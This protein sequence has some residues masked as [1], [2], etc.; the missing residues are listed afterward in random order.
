M[1]SRRF[2]EKHLPAYA[3]SASDYQQSLY[4]KLFSGCIIPYQFSMEL[5]LADLAYHIQ[6][7]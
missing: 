5:F 3:A 6:P 7:G 1:G 2:P 4:S